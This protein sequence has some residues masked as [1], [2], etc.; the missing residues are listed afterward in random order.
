[1]RTRTALLTGLL[2]L[3][4]G[5]GSLPVYRGQGIT[6]RG[7]SGIPVEVARGSGTTG[8][9]GTRTQ[10]GSE[11]GVSRVEVPASGAAQVIL[12]EV[13]RWYGTPYVYGGSTKN[14]TDCSGFTQSVYRTVGIEIPR[15]ASRQAAAARNVSR[16]SLRP[17]DLV[18]FNTSGSGISHVGIYLGD[19]HFAHAATSRGVV[20]ESLSHPYYTTRFVHG[21]RFLD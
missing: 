11:A 19:G 15:R 6:C 12:D 2:L 9:G 14:G 20:R 18:F 21:G 4:Q 1:M 16:G 3:A 5:C 10:G 17:G 7:P 8:E 13:G